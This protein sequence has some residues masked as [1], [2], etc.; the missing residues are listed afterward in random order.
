MNSTVDKLKCK[1]GSIVGAFGAP[2][3]PIQQDI[4]RQTILTALLSPTRSRGHQ[5]PPY[6]Q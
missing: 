3:L 6:L 2:A 5:L 1:P 4:N